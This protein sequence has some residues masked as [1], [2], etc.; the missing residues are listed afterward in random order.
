MSKGSSDGLH[1]YVDS[2]YESYVAC[3]IYIEAY[4]PESLYNKTYSKISFE[5]AML[6]LKIKVQKQYGEDNEEK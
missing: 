4:G 3:E 6:K 1:L 5:D 2:D